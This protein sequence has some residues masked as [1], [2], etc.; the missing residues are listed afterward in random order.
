MVLWDDLL[1]VASDWR[2]KYSDNE[3]VVSYINQAVSMLA[4][5]QKYASENHKYYS[6]FSSKAEYDDAVKVNE[7]YSMSTDELRPYVDGTHTS[8]SGQTHGGGGRSLGGDGTWL[9]ELID[10]AKAKE[11]SAIAYTTSTGQNIT[12]QQLYDRKKQEEDFNDLY[13][14]LSSNADFKDYVSKGASIKNPSMK[15]AE[16]WLQIGN[17]RAGATAQAD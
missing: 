7:L 5:T 14:S 6:Q 11:S 13:S 16:G 8:S 1:S 2:N 4:E 17:W 15:D 9:D 12:W 3:E 10:K